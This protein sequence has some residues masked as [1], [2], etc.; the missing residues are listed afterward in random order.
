MTKRTCGV[1][2][3]TFVFVL[4]ISDAALAQAPK[5]F[6]VSEIRP[7]MKGTGRTVFQGTTIEDFQVEVLGVLKNYGPKQDMILAR[8]SGGP[9][10]KTGVVQGMSGSPVYIDGRLIGAVAFAF[11]YATQSVAGIQPIEQMTGVLDQM[12]AAPA[13]KGVP[14]SASHPLE[15]PAA[16]VYRIVEKLK[17]GRPIQE[18]FG[19]ALSP[20]SVPSST[21]LVQLQTPLFLS[22]V[23]A[24]A[25]QQFSSFFSGLGFNPV[26]GGAAGTVANVGPVSNRLEPGS[27]VSAELV[28]GDMNISANGTVTYVD[29]NKVYAFGHPFL[30]AG[31]ISVPMSSAY[32]I[33]LLP[34]LDTSIKL[35]FPVDVVGA[36]QQDRSTGVFGTMGD[37]PNMIPVELNVRSSTNATNHYN[38]EVA[39]DRYLTPI[40]MNYAVVNAITASERGVGEMTLSV[41]GEVHIRNN[42]SV[43]IATMFS[44]DGNGPSAATAAAVAPIQ[45]LVTGGYDG[46]IIDKVDFQIVSTDRKTLATLDR[47][48]VDRNEVH[49]GET[50]ALSALM[51]EPN[52]QTFI[53]RYSVLIPPGLSAGTVQ[54]LVGDGTTMT[55]ME[56]KRSP[57]GIPMDLTTVI[58]E[59]NKL[60]R[61]DRLYVRVLSN[62]PGVVIRG[63]EMP[64]LPPSMIG[65]LDTDRASSRNVTSMGS[66]AV[67][68]Y[69]FPQ[70]KYVIQGQQSLTLTIKP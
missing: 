50:V 29:G 18:L 10:E 14:A 7:G 55:G 23:T 11:P 68:E 13:L 48:T 69:E 32:V 27:T 66:S 65:L 20:A 60:R 12:P 63:E 35:A 22:G 16:F 44:G 39:N 46:L 38:V 1:L 41:T 9:L 37:K 21:S 28:R 49:P 64:S 53:E 62:Q 58:R 56:L 52:G 3:L 57:S 51:R 6:P 36:F 15:S 47:I 42:D 61:N 45:Y 70:S 4:M 8:L 34:K 24:A 33:S 54:L 67:A 2:L 43:K 19:P 17:E 5:F 40:L 25:A 31:P 26:Q 59:L 30:S